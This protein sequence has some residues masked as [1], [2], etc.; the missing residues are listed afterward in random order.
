[1]NRIT[2]AVGF[3]IG[4]MMGYALL[5]ALLA[6]AGGMSQLET[7]P[8]FIQNGA[9]PIGFDVTCSSNATPAAA[10]TVLLASDTITRERIIQFPA[11]QGIQGIC[12]FASTQAYSSG[13]L[14]VPP[15]PA[16]ACDDTVPGVELSTATNGTQILIEH[17]TS[18]LWCRSRANATAVGRLKGIYYRDRR[19]QG[20][21]N[22][23]Q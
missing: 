12:I 11:S 17:G 6:H 21:I 18:T 2:R 4:L 1:M 7:D 14:G 15:D 16:Q 10:W 5:G 13:G 3:A 9:N 23:N 20:L 8:T 22:S 19:D